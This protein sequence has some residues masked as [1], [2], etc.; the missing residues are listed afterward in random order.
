VHIAHMQAEHATVTGDLKCLCANSHRVLHR[1][2]ALGLAQA[3]H[4]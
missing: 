4:A 3:G 1:R 2:L